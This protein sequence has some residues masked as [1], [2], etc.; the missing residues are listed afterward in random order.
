LQGDELVTRTLRVGSYPREPSPV[1][2]IPAG[3]TA[4]L[5]LDDVHD[6]RGA[7]PP[8]V[9][10]RVEASFALPAADQREVAGVYPDRHI[11]DD[12]DHGGVRREYRQLSHRSYSMKRR[13][14]PAAWDAEHAR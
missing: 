9:T 4:L 14:R 8:T 10:H 5:L 13:Q 11:G 6:D 2:S 7:I 3:Q 12:G 1:T